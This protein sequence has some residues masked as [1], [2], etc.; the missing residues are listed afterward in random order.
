MYD[1]FVASVQELQNFP[2]SNVREELIRIG[3][4]KKEPSI[5]LCPCCGYCHLQIC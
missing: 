1:A 4:E 5:L 2:K 3:G